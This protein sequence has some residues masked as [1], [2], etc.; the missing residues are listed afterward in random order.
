MKVR[1]EHLYVV[2]PQEQFWTLLATSQ[3]WN[4][5]VVFNAFTSRRSLMFWF[6]GFSLKSSGAAATMVGDAISALSTGEVS[7]TLSSSP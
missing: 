7:S 6:H 1:I 4:V 5:I 2:F 3:M